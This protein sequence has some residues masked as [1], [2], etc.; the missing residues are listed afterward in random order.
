M[1]SLL[2]ITGF[3]ILLVLS[4]YVALHAEEANHKAES[5]SKPDKKAD[6]KCHL[7]FDLAG[8]SVF[9]K[10]ADGTGVIRCN[11]GQHAEVG[12][13]SRGG[14][15]TFGKHEIKNGSGTFTEVRDIS[16]LFGSYAET[17]AH[18]GAKGS[19]GAHAMTKGDI[20]LAISGTGKGYDL[21]VDFGRFKITPLKTN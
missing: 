16:E 8:W 3:A 1:M 14:G 21:G 13:H 15:I 9:Y 2:R 11:N 17:S 12:I 4:P 5:N 7:K 18:A 10:T 19:A 6:V 20:S